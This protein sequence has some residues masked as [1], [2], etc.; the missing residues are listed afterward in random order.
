MVLVP[1]PVVPQTKHTDKQ[2]PRQ[3]ARLNDEKRVNHYISKK[4]GLDKSSNAADAPT[5]NTLN[6]P[7]QCVLMT[8]PRTHAY[9]TKSINLAACSRAKVKVGPLARI[10]LADEVYITALLAAAFGNISHAVEVAY[11]AER[12]DTQGEPN[13]ARFGNILHAAEVSYGAELENAAR[14]VLYGAVRGA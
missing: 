5:G 2:R 8:S 14:A 3:N 12:K 9:G 6:G 4:D 11:G 10:R 13:G 1:W 7:E